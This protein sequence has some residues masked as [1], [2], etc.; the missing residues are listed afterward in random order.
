MK[1][2]IEKELELL[3]KS[4]LKKFK[5]EVLYSV[6]VYNNSKKHGLFITKECFLKTMKQHKEYYKKLIA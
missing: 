6:K 2:D 4:S 5:E 1:M 3:K